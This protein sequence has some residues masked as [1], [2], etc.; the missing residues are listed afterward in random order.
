MPGIAWLS[1][2]AHERNR[3][4][5]ESRLQIGYRRAP[6]RGA[7]PFTNRY[8]RTPVIVRSLAS[9]RCGW[10][11]GALH[12]AL[13]GVAEALLGLER[14]QHDQYRKSGYPDGEGGQ[15]SA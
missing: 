12:R 3:E 10:S 8:I 11:D 6:Q 5:E 2:K 7:L 15:L 14:S 1:E 13:H 4:A 9:F